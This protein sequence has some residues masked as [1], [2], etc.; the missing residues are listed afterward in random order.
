MDGANAAEAGIPTGQPPKFCQSCNGV[1]LTEQP[2]SCGCL[3]GPTKNFNYGHTDIFLSVWTSLNLTNGV[4]LWRNTDGHTTDCFLLKSYLFFS[5]IA[6]LYTILCKYINVKYLK[7]Y[8]QIC[9]SSMI[10]M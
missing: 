10:K 6:K 9:S 7:K 4:F 3:N 1:A 5:S 2:Y 8:I